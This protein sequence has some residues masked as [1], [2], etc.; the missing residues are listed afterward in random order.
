MLRPAPSRARLALLVLAGLLGRGGWPAAP[1]L[2][3]APPASVAPDRLMADVN[4]LVGFGT[5]HTLS[6][7]NPRAA[8]WL[9]ERFRE[10]GCDEV[11]L[12]DFPIGPRTRHNVVATIRGRQRPDEFVLVGAHYDSRNA[13]FADSRGPAPGAND[14]AS[15]TA[16]LLELARL[17]A[18]DPPGRS[19]R[20]VAFSGEEQ[21]LL[22]SRSYAKT[23]RDEGIP[24]TLMINLDMIGHP[25]DEA[26]RALIVEHDPGL[27]SPSNDAP[28][29]AW[30][31]RLKAHVA[32]NG[33]EPVPGVLYG[34]D[35]MPFEANGVV[36]VGLFDGAD[37]ADFYHHEADTP[38]KVDASYCS[39]ATAAALALIREAAD[40]AFEI[41]P[42]TAGAPVDDARPS[43]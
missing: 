17:L 19:V 25:M 40:P 6:D 9:A 22:G 33:L 15:G 39:S 11:S 37:A 32:A 28:S 34:S 23:C 26:R 43:P 30:A 5:R 1:A 2:A 8:D 36:C 12:H 29:L 27:R 4:A 14:N 24:I 21:G 41:G 18:V 31:D 13:Q 35:Y 38:D 10:A 42:K 20:L 7:A 16:A 3:D